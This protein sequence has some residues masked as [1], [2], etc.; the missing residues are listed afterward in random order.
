MERTSRG[1]QITW[2]INQNEHKKKKKHSRFSLLTERSGSFKVFLR[3][4]IYSSTFVNKGQYLTWN[5]SRWICKKI[6]VSRIAPSLPVRLQKLSRFVFWHQWINL[7]DTPMRETRKI[8]M[9]LSWLLDLFFSL[10]FFSGQIWIQWLGKGDDRERISAFRSIGGFW[11]RFYNFFLSL[12]KSST[13]MTT[14]LHSSDS[15]QRQERHSTSGVNHLDRTHFAPHTESREDSDSLDSRQ[16]T[17]SFFTFFSYSSS[18]LY[19][20]PFRDIYFQMH[21][22]VTRLHR[23]RH[24]Y[25]DLSFRSSVR[26]KDNFD[27]RR[28]PKVNSRPYLGELTSHR[29]H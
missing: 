24:N 17:V 10:S 25:F 11:N 14:K 22:S 21:N 12:H 19:S 9:K 15:R 4:I 28:V 1:R 3:L 6:C 23:R 16:T 8:S 18:L 5:W 27:N 26:K 7:R 13:T 20:S 2:E 29:K